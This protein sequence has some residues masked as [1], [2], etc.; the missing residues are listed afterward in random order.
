M[1][2][3]L[4][5]TL[6]APPVSAERPPFVS[7]LPRASAFAIDC[8]VIYFAGFTLEMMLRAPLL[9]LGPWLP[10]LGGVAAFIYFWLANGPVGGGTTLGKAI[11]NIKIVSAAPGT[12]GQPLDLASS[13]KRTL[14]QFP[15]VYFSTCVL[16]V[17]L[18]DPPT[19]VGNIIH[20]SVGIPVTTLMI[21]LVYTIISHQQFAGWHDRFALSRVTPDSIPKAFFDVL[22]SGSF[23]GVAPVTIQQLDRTRRFARMFFFAIL[24]VIGAGFVPRW[25]NPEVR[26]SARVYDSIQKEIPLKGFD[27]VSVNYLPA[28]IVR[29]ILA[30][31]E[32]SAESE[33]DPTD[34]ATDNGTPAGIVPPDSE[35]PLASLEIADPGG[36]EES[37][38]SESISEDASLYFTWVKSRGT[39]D[40]SGGLPGDLATQLETF[41]QR[42]LDIVPPPSGENSPRLGPDSQIFFYLSDDF[43][44]VL[45]SIGERSAWRVHGPLDP[46][47]G[48]LQIEKIEVAKKHEDSDSESSTTLASPTPTPDSPHSATS[49]GTPIEDPQP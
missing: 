2:E 30:T 4:N 5:P 8:I 47:L 7:M 33:S 40:L 16:F 19:M 28:D 31:E 10:G 46:E 32:D 12:E 23:D 35:P 44:W 13:F 25:F 42:V 9:G 17:D 34:S 48:P 15:F 36:L 6:K 49:T 3:E 14:I 18:V 1:P 45:I 43:R 11:V 27:L 39:L 22:P 20:Q 24:C 41:R 38:A 37:D 26:K 21:T 29:R